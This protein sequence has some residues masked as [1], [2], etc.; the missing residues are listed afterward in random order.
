VLGS[1]DLDAGM[2]YLVME[3]LTGQTLGERLR[4]EP[5]LSPAATLE[6]VRHVARGLDAIAATGIVHRDLKPQNLFCTS[7]GTWKILDFGVAS[8]SG[9]TGTLTRGEAVGTPHYMAP[10]QAQGLRVDSRADTYALAAIA[11]RCLTGRYPFTATDTPALLYA[12]VHRTPAR[13]GA[14]AELPADVDRY[15]ALA[16]AKKPDDRFATA[17]DVADALA[18]ALDGALDPKL[19][20]RADA[21][22]RKQPWSAA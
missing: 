16:L 8:L 11:Y 13:P 15:F 12:V 19:R 20:R 1:S 3:R 14:L 7:D 2:P 17:H 6:L 21:Y 5:R 22:L 10:E 18:A 4:R 9:D